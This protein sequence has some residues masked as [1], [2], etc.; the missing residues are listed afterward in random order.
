MNEIYNPKSGCIEFHKRKLCYN[1]RDYAYLMLP[2]LVAKLLHR[3]YLPLV[4]IV[5]RKDHVEIWPDKHVMVDG[6]DEC[7]A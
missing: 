7:W 4:K 2:R 3:H 5:M 1:G 6:M